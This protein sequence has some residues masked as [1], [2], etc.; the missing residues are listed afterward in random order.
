MMRVLL[1]VVLTIGIGLA[2]LLDPAS[3]T[4]RDAFTHLMRLGTPLLI[5]PSIVRDVPQ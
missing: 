4:Y 2:L 5:V 1:A 3:T